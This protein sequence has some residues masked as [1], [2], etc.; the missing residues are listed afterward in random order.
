M[1]AYCSGA[2]FGKEAYTPE[3]RNSQSS[4]VVMLKK[5]L[6]FVV[7]FIAM[8]ELASFLYIK[9]VN[10]NIQMPS[11]SFVNVNSKF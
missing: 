1:P 3:P 7:T 10:T 5:L 2:A 9:Y 4:F 11:Y 6:V 8:L